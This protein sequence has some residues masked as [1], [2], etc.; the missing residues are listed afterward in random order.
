M[1]DYLRDLGTRSLR[2][3]EGRLVEEYTSYYRQIA[4][5]KE[6]SAA[7]QEELEVR[8]AELVEVKRL[9]KEREAKILKAKES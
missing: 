6:D 9:V 1:P 5:L 3:A 4:G 8:R 7:G 2:G